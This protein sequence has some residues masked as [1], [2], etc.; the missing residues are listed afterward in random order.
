MACSNLAGLPDLTELALSPAPDLHGSTLKD[1]RCVPKLKVLNLSETAIDDAHA[2]GRG[3]MLQPAV[4]RSQPHLD[5][6]QGPVS[7]CFAGQSEIPRPLQLAGGSMQRIFS[8][9]KKVQKP[10]RRYGSAVRGFR[11]N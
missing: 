2:V 7:T 5:Q 4:P 10:A 3:S 8:L 9:L 1:L 6:F 11:L